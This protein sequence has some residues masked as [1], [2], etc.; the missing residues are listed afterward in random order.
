MLLKIPTLP[1]QGR[2]GHLTPVQESALAQLKSELEAA[3]I[4][5][6]YDDNLFLRFLRARKFDVEAA[7]K[8]FTDYHN[9]RVEEKVDTLR[10]DFQL[11]EYPI[12]ITLSFLTLLV[13]KFYPRFYH[14]TDKLGRPV[15]FEVL[16]ELNVTQL[17]A[18]CPIEKLLRNHVYEY[19]KLVNYR[20]A[21]CSLKA[22]VYLEQSCTVLDL[23]GVALSSFSSIY[24]TVKEISAIAQNNYP[25][26][27]G[28]MFIINSPMLFTSVWYLV[29]QL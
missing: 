17:T 9:W 27:L 2:A 6:T 20:L 21:A 10:D 25:E 1:T 23:K 4:T 22:G 14:K 13:K 19:E 28:K 5:G 26:S 3:S 8:M 11:P 18:V 24:S 15:Y 7:K 29:K 16:G 12:S